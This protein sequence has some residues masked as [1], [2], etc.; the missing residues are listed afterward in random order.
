MS[1]YAAYNQWANETILQWLSQKPESDFYQEVPSSHRSI[2]LTLN[3]ILAV[4]EFWHA[5][6]SKSAPASQRY[7]A[8]EANHT[9]VFAALAQQSAMLGAYISGLSEADLQEEIYLNMPWVQGTL[10]RY[11]FIQ[12]VF[13]HSTYHRGQVVNIG[14]QLGYT[15]A[16][17]TDYN[18]FN[19]A[20]GQTA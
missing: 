19:M 18:Y 10:P 9:E 15:D 4:E 7:M 14:R 2:A 1:N 12:H 17:M 6:I 8:T 20:V 5:V 11:E 13:N 16:P 3:H